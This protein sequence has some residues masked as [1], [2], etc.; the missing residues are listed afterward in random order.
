MSQSSLKVML[1]DLSVR[2]VDQ[3][4]DKV[5]GKVTGEEI[6]DS[7]ILRAKVMMMTMM[8]EMAMGQDQEETSDL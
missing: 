2:V 3:A 7:K 8:I 6:E 1:A 4:A 5:A